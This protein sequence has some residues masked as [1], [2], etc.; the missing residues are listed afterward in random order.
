[1]QRW[2]GGDVPYAERSPEESSRHLHVI[3]APV[4]AAACIRVLRAVVRVAQRLLCCV[5]SIVVDCVD[6][7]RVRGHEAVLGM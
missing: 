7:G 6:R 3:P 1:M 2:T 5:G 4:I